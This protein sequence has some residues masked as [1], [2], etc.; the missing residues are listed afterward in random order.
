MKAWKRLDDGTDIVEIGHKSV[1][2]KKFRM[3]SGKVIHADISGHEGTKAAIVYA[4]TPAGE[5]IVA[6]QFRCGP[7]TVM[8]EMPAGLV[9]PG[10]TP[11]EAARRELIEEVG[12]TSDNIELV[13]TAYV[14]AWDSGLHYYYIAHDCYKVDNATN[15]D[16]FEEIEVTTISIAELFDNAR[17]ARMTDVQGVFLA[18]DK[19]RELEEKQSK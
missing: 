19:L 6:R 2:R 7:E 4:L 10:E 13:G 9:D 14:N 18:Y 3:N 16:E 15:P 1:I 12:Y 11:L 8:E 5:I 17:N